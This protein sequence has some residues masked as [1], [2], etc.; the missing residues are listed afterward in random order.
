MQDSRRNRAAATVAQARIDHQA[1]PFALS[2]NTLRV[3]S[4]LALVVFCTLDLLGCYHI[5]MV[6]ERG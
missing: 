2:Q 1:P 5:H 3:H 4:F 6:A